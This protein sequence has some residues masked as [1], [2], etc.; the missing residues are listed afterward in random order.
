M[1][2]LQVVKELHRDARKNFAHRRSVMRGI[3]E[4][5]QAD[6]IEMPPDRG[7]KYCLTVIDIFSKMAYVRPLKTKTGP[8]VTRAMKT[9][10]DSIERPVKNLN[11]DRGKE[12]YNSDMTKLLEKYRINRYSTYSSKKAAIVERFNRTIKNK[13]HQQFSLR[14]NYKWLDILPELVDEYNRSRHRTIKMA[15]KEVDSDN[16]QQLLDT[17][18][19]YK[20]I[21]P[22]KNNIKFRIGD[23]I[24]LS[25]YKN[26]FAKGYL[27]NW[28]TEIFTVKKIQYTDP[29]TYLLSDWDGNDIKGGVYAEEMQKVK[30][31]DV[32]LVEKIL[33]RK[34]NKVYVKWLGFDNRFNSWVNENDVL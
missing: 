13:I 19:N 9:V 2:K 31:P 8:E 28:T 16:E 11:V 12:F 34:N 6:L 29:I 32:Y 15:P 7:M 25:K 33:R 22:A 20:R 18:Y 3:A 14:G 17:V 30:Y 1:S 4:T 26:V 21:I 5:L 10:L 24:R 27:P 23:H